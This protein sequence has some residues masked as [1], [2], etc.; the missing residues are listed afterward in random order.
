MF[1]RKSSH[2]KNILSLAFDEGKLD[3]SLLHRNGSGPLLKQ[4][5]KAALSLDILKDD[6]DLVGQEI[7]N[8]LD[9]LGIKE[10][11]C[12]ICLPVYWVMSHQIELPEMSAEDERNYIQLNAEREFPF[13]YDELSLSTLKCQIPN[14]ASV[15]LLN[16]VPMQTVIK[17]REICKAAKLSPVSFSIGAPIIPKSS[18]E[19]GTLILQQRETTVDC[20]VLY[21]NQFVLMR[22]FEYSGSVYETDND[23][24][25]SLLRDIRISLG[26]LPDGVRESLKKLYL[27]GNPQWNSAIEQA[28]QPAMQS[29]RIQIFHIHLESIV[30]KGGE[31]TELHHPY[32]ALGTGARL[33]ENGESSI[34]FLPPCISPIQ[35]VIER[36]SSRR[37][38]VLGGGA[39]AAILL[40][41][42][43]F[44]WQQW[45][46][47]SY[48]SQ[49]E[50]T[51][52]KVEE[53]EM[54]QSKIKQFHPWFQDS[55]PSL[56]AIKTMTQ[57]FPEEGRVWT[58]VVEIEDTQQVSCSGFA[59][60]NKDLLVAID[61]LNQ[62]E[63]VKDLQIQQVV[64]E[65]PVQFSF[66][67][68]WIQGGRR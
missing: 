5:G 20:F 34:E 10:N 57:A 31:L 29:I 68:R 39:A 54:I 48:E 11:H 36:I 67:Y 32:L 17:I 63:Q 16:A 9:E 15:A 56:S 66:R 44:G 30:H 6:S 19:E 2:R 13:P 7:R 23:W 37:N 64:G 8:R 52:D 43:L 45:T 51:R 46:L 21:N 40:G 49:W 38:A 42:I 62:D 61:Q 53:L 33:L 65:S 14:Y 27:Y 50:A 3:V 35:K 28:L 22:N 25:Q 1:D 24:E 4:A 47:S 18:S 55:V 58:K 12:L 60:N 59:Q 41:V 26:Q